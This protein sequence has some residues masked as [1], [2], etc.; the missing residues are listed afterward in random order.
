MFVHKIRQIREDTDRNMGDSSE[1]T[2]KVRRKT[3]SAHDRPKDLCHSW[4]H[5]LDRSQKGTSRITLADSQFSGLFVRN[6]AV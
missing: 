4:N 1:D 2:L 5:G 6:S 3:S